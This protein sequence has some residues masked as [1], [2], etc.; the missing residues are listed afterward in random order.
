MQA[1]IWAASGI[2][3]GWFAGRL[4]KGRDYG[5]VGNLILGLLGG[6]VGGWLVHLLGFASPK[7]HLRHAVVG[8][9]DRK[10]IA[11]QFILLVAGY[12]QNARI[13]EYDSFILHHQNT[14]GDIVDNLTIVLF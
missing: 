11:D 4:I 2:L 1:L 8:V 5:L 3:A 10:D 6:L 9:N 7:D 13:G 12:L 14:F